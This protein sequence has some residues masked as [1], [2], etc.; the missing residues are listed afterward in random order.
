MV[1]QLSLRNHFIVH[2]MHNKEKKLR[3]EKKLVKTFNTK[4]MGI[5]DYAFGIHFD[6]DEKS[7]NMTQ[8]AYIEKII[9]TYNL[10]GSKI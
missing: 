10:K 2:Q 1:N 4:L 8:I 6:W 5:L 3:M 7:C 9:K